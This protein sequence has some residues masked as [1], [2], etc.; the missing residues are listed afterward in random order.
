[1]PATVAGIVIAYTGFSELA[2]AITMPA[3]SIFLV[4]MLTLGVLMWRRDG[5]GAA[6]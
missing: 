5:K 1:V 6:F 4:W 2:M 3:S